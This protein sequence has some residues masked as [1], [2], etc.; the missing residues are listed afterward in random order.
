MPKKIT[1]NP[2]ETS[3][4]FVLKK[5]PALIE[6]IKKAVK[7]SK[8]KKI[9]SLGWGWFSCLVSTALDAYIEKMESTK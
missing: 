1:N 2:A 3:S 7:V 4:P 8:D 9:K 5:T 6:K